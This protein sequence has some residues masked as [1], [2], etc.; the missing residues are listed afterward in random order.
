[1]ARAR[2]IKPGFFKNY[3]LADLGPHAQLLFAGLWCL[4]DKEGRLKDQP[5]LIKAE[6]FPYYEVDVNGELT[7]LERLAFIDRYE[8]DGMAI[9][10]VANFVEHQSPHHTEKASTLPCKD[11]KQ[12]A[13]PMPEPLTDIH[14]DLTVNLQNYNGGNPSDSLIHRFTDSLIPDSLKPDSLI[15]ENFQEQPLATAVAIAPKKNKSAEDLPNPLNLET[16]N[17]YKYAYTNRYTV[18]PVR[19][20]AVNSKIKSLVKALGQEA[21]AVAAFF[22]SHN[23]SRYVA[24]MHQIG[25]LVTDYAKLRTEWATNTRMTTTK[26]QQA[27]KTATNHDAFAHL[28]A[29]AEARERAERNQHDI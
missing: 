7:K 23:G 11:E 15:A 21:P 3:D 18:A 16:W 20:A 2:N 9:I 6:I 4:A 29:E 5:R 10:Q 22:V 12:A 24:G 1:M 14:G 19:D 26:A 13:K 8:V 25:F 27:D 17:A 28:I